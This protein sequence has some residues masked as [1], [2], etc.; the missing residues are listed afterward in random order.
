VRLA[1][2]KYTEN[3]TDL[4]KRCMHLTNYS[5][6]VKK[7]EFTMGASA[8]GEDDVG[9]KRSVS[10]LRRKFEAE[11]LDWHRVWVGVKDIVTKTMVS[12]EVRA[13]LNHHVPPLRLPIQ[14]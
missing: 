10:S 6:N 8:V 12:V 3:G 1:T 13:F 11:N 2:E 5:V 14:D 7:K 9:F 4:S